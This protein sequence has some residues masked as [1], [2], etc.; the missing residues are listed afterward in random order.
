MRGLNLRLLGRP[1]LEF[2]GHPLTRLIGAKPQ[3]L[4]Y[5]LATE[6]GGPVSRAQLASLLWGA[7]DD[8]SARA[9]L[10]LALT[11]LRQRLPGV[12]EADAQAVGLSLQVPA[13]VDAQRVE[14]AAQG[15]DDLP[16]E[17]LERAAA[18]CGGAFLEGFDLPGADAF[19]EWL[20]RERA[21]F[22]RSAVVVMRR[23]VDR[24]DQAGAV[25][26]AIA[27]AQRWVELD[28]T[29]EA[30]HRRLMELLAKSGRRTAA[31][32]QYESLRTILVDSL[33]AR[34][35][36]QTYELYR[37]IH[38][39]A[40]R[41]SIDEEP[42]AAPEARAA[43]P[44]APRLTEAPP[45][46]TGTLVGRQSELV[47]A[48]Q[49]LLD[50]MC[51]LL[52]LVGPGGIGKTRL[53]LA[54]A[55]AHAG[56]F[57]DGAVFVSAA[58][59]DD[60]G[61]RVA[62]L[63]DAIATQAGA[64]RGGFVGAGESLARALA[65]RRMLL[66]LDNL[67][68]VPEAGGLVS[69]LVEGAPGIKVLAT[70]R[71]RLGGRRE[72][73][74]EV[75]GLSLARG[76]GDDLSPAARLF[77]REASRLVTG[78]DPRA[79]AACVE[80]VCAM[81]G[82]VPLAI[83]IAARAV[84]AHGCAGLAERIGA[85]GGL[86]DPDRDRADRH[87]SIEAI[88]LD[89]WA[90]LAPS[91]RDA[92]MRL[93]VLPGAFD[94]ALA[95]VVAGVSPEDIG[96][97]RDQSWLRAEAD[98]RL[99][100]HP[101]QRDF[102]LRQ[103]R[104][105]AGLEDEVL[106]RLSGRWLAA[107]RAALEEAA[108]PRATAVPAVAAAPVR[109]DA[110]ALEQIRAC[111]AHR[112]GRGNDEELAGFVDVAAGFLCAAGAW[113]DAS[114]LL[115]AAVARESL[116]AWRRGL[117]VLR[118][119]GIENQA[120]DVERAR[121]DF[122]QGL[123]LLGYC[124]GG[125]ARA[126][127]HELAGVLAGRKTSGGAPWRED[128]AAADATVAWAMMASGQLAAFAGE[129]APSA[130]LAVLAWVLGRRARDR[131]VIAMA[132][133]GFAYGGALMR[134]GR[135][136]R[137]LWRRASRLVSPPDRSPVAA[138][139]NETIGACEYAAG[140]WHRALPR[141]DETA[142]AMR[143]FQLPRY[144]VECRSLAA[145][146]LALQGRFDEAQRRF[147]AFGDAVRG[148]ELTLLRH[149]SLLGVVETATRTGS[150]DPRELLRLLAEARHEMSEI[151]TIDSAYVIRWLGLQAVVCAMAGDA[152]GAREAAL[153]GAGVIARD[154]LPGAWAHEGFGGI[155][156]TL[157]ACRDRDRAVGLSGADLEPALAQAL[158]GMARQADRFPPG[159]ARLHYCRAQLAAGD[160]RA[161]EARRQMLRAAQLADRYGMRYE[162]ARACERLAALG[163][164][165]D[166][167][168]W[169]RRAR[170]LYE[171]TGARIDLGRVAG[172]G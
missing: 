50:P 73:L 93:A 44:E 144:E 109:V 53:A 5:Y 155:V 98:A 67:E 9:N 14:A 164:A 49:R 126:F 128:G 7:L 119:A 27:S 19:D 4:V 116:P 170:S 139:A 29:D 168:S 81:V 26:R 114:R 110:A 40:P 86:V 21:R 96:R 113:K 69:A 172:G 154:L 15:D 43:W 92:L 34:P 105:V 133:G 12:L 61:D 48:G 45:G 143:R 90:T 115:S 91:L 151:Q 13:F 120:G 147:A 18:C 39:D 156:E 150:H 95:R 107:M 57:A 171:E 137:W 159:R 77:V 37:R 131:D 56:R 141:L 101:L 142:A 84:R 80:R 162:L 76:P 79:N 6:G 121:R 127:G 17:A 163:P 158:R 99:S 97:L 2:D 3:A 112:A 74:Y 52:T 16:L 36:A 25:E 160:G 30:A 64:R 125:S 71:R 10:R 138:I 83:E 134:Q 123:E 54:I 32:A 103:A 148:S 11:R 33:G 72:W 22:Q 46:E 157:I 59:L 152:E 122:A 89:A 41:A 58:A 132:L 78:F 20:R 166:A 82:G 149:W 102:A 75:P 135:A 130:R 28:D 117:S 24:L 140:Q 51:R 124:G 87:H 1:R 118:K 31:I 94:S 108:P 23:V 65:G 66:V 106:D 161:R 88:V 68:T 167:Q 8:A 47:E 63:A 145:K 129:V 153:S 136:V 100:I 62:M 60:G 165:A 38:A 111:A 146:I 55:D 85:G 104:A 42:A 35:S 70:S 169:L